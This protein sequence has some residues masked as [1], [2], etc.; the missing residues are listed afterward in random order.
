MIRN[1]IFECST[2]NL[3]EVVQE[4]AKEIEAGYHI[5]RLELLDL[6]M[7]MRTRPEPSFRVHLERR[8]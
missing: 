3:E 4:V 5:E 7:S 1:K 8:G 6:T 2:E